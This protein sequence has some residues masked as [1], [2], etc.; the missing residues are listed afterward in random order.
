MKRGRSE[1][2]GAMP[3][4]FHDLGLTESVGSESAE[5]D[6]DDYLLVQPE[7]AQ[8]RSTVPTAAKKRPSRK[9]LFD[10]MT[11]AFNLLAVLLS[12]DK[13]FAAQI[14]TILV[15]FRSVSE[16]IDESTAILLE[17]QSVPTTSIE[18]G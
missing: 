14:G 3:A 15:P 17:H 13:R 12:R 5:Q 7:N 16:L 4:T 10:A 6:V 1:I 8:N 11:S 2:G 18:H 9:Q